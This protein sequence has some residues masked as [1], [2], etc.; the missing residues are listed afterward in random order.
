MQLTADRTERSGS[1]SRLHLLS[2]QIIKIISWL[3][4]FPFFNLCL[5]LFEFSLTAFQVLPAGALS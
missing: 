4:S 1:L 5:N 2:G 3:R